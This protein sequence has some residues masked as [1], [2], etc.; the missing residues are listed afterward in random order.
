MKIKV[1]WII[2]SLGPGGAEQLTLEYLKKFD[3]KLFEIRVCVLQNRLGNPIETELLKN[4]IP[5]DHVDVSNLRNVTNL[6]RLIKYLKTT[7]PDIVH[8]QLQFSDIL[9]ALASRILGIPCVSTQH[10]RYEPKAGTDFLRNNLTWFVLR[11]FSD[12]VIAVSEDTRNF[13]KIKGRISDK[14]IITIYNGID[15]SRYHLENKTAPTSEKRKS[16]NLPETG[17]IFSTVAV[18][19]EQKGIQYMIDAVAN[20]KKEIP[21]FYYLIVGDGEYREALKEKVSE[22]QLENTVI[23]IG[24]REDINEILVAC[25][26][27]VLPTLIEALPTV[28]IEAMASKKPAIASNV[29]GVPEM[30]E[31]LKNG[32]LTAPENV[33][34]LEKACIKLGKDEILR[35]HLGEQGAII[36]QEKFEINNT[37]NKIKHLYMSLLKDDR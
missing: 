12:K 16:L 31:D 25:D 27:F 8:T 32:I 3:K 14:K 30:I 5:V 9:G 15:L 20:I 21:N 17:L 22:K 26:V 13:H 2:D 35:K 29:G 6:P 37:I 34:E 24:H 1:I 4:N 36:A 33:E 18:L 11:N 19:R 10:T 28:L 7:K 23:F